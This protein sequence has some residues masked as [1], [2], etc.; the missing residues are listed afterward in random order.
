MG[1]PSTSGKG[2]YASGKPTDTDSD[3]A[4]SSASDDSSECGTLSSMPTGDALSEEGCDDAV[5]LF[6]D[7]AFPTARECWDFMERE[8]AF[9]LA[10]IRAA[11]GDAWSPYHKIRLVN[12]LR[13]LGPDKARAAI[14]SSIGL[15][16]PFWASDEALIPVRADDALLIIDDTDE[17]EWIDDTEREEDHHR[18]LAQKVDRACGRH[19]NDDAGNGTEELGVSGPRETVPGVVQEEVVVKTLA[20]DV[21]QELKREEHLLFGEGKGYVRK[22]DGHTRR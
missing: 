10:R 3:D 19:T 9:S 8:Y 18:V 17:D 20:A 6:C 12:R 15:D 14:A 4:A 22:E 13:L 7:T 5:S 11:W 2:T 1:K 21:L 16:E